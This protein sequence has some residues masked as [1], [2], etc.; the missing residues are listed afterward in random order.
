MSFT[1]KDIIDYYEK[2]EISFR[3]VWDLN[4]SLA[5]HY[6]YSDEKAKT[7][8]KSLMRFNEVL[9]QQTAITKND[10]VFDAGCGVGG[11][12]I[13]LA[14]QYGCKVVGA[15]ICP[16]QVKAATANALKHG[17]AHLV[18]FSEMDYCNTGFKD[19]MFTVVWGLESI[20]Y[21]G[22]K[23][24]FLKQA[25]RI[26]KKGGRLIV[27]DGF[28]AKR[29]YSEAEALIMKNYLDGWA[30]NAIDTPEQFE[31][32]ARELGFKNLSFRDVSKQVMPSSKKMFYFSIP[33]IILAKLQ[34][35][36]RLISSL[37]AKHSVT[38]YNQY[39]AL[40]KG[41]WKYGIFFAEKN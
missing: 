21:A 1:K 20:C 24:T 35:S 18:A 40:K 2:S 22:D 17:V 8:R 15:T 19:E 14:K 5:I 31:N 41:L 23:R 16:H 29:N 11:S 25:Y 13:Y 12:S 27:A 37:E 28:A 9:A 3:L 39:S 6:G 33:A 7:F 10:F 26:L 38:L 4:H 30:V 32:S 36:L 34:R